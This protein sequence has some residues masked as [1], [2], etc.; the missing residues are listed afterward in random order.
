MLLD[1]IDTLCRGACR[2]APDQPVIVGVSGGPDSLCLLDLLVRLGYPLI[3]AHFDHGLRLEAQEDARA[4]ADVAAGY[5]LPF[6][7]DR[8][9]VRALAAS[10][11]QTIEEAGRAARYRFLFDQARQVGA[12]AVAVGHNADD[13]VETVLMHLLR[14]AGLSGL[15]GMNFRSVLPEWDDRVPLVRPLLS[16]WREEVDAYCAER[17]LS[18]RQD[19]SNQDVTYY[20]NRLRRDLVPY[21]QSYNPRVKELIWRSAET[22]AGDAEIV[23]AVAQEAWVSCAPECGPG[24]QSLS[25]PVFRKLL[26]GLQ[27]RVLRQAISRLRP[28]L[29]DVDFEAVERGVAFALSPASTGQ[30]DF[31]QGL[32][33]F[34]ELDRLYLAD[35]G[36]DLPVEAYPQVETGWEGLIT[37][38]GTLDLPHG[39]R[40]TAEYIPIDS[41]PPAIPRD[42]PSE[43]WLDAETLDLP[44]LVH[45]PAPGIRFQPLGMAGRS[46]KLSDFWVNEKL[47]RRLRPG[48]PLVFSGDTL[49]WIPFYRPAHPFRVR[50]STRK[51]VRLIITRN[52]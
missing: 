37:V 16:T 11:K 29:R 4:V 21:L 5:Q 1:R 43:G 52:Q 34:I 17:E 36:A 23:T 8:A 40:I 51:A 27:R 12:Q 49:A 22:L 44:L 26:P 33:L 14:G 20:R 31:L 7:T 46:L 50:E 6:V 28:G 18:P 45:A 19:A 24:Y 32:R 38:P 42:D 3:V 9:D 13:Q 15:K 48:W 2:L 47:P 35:W 41:Y 25:L 30:M 10:Q 39:W